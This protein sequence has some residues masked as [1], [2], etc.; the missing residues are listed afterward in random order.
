MEMYL[1]YHEE[2]E[3]LVKNFPEIQRIRFWMTFSKE[4]LNHLHVLQNVGL[5]S[6][7][8]I[9]FENH[10]VIPLKFLKTILPEPSTLGPV[11]KGKT[12]IGCLTEGIKMGKD[13]K[14]YI[15]TNCDHEASFREIGS[16]AISYT[17][18][19]PAMVGAKLILQQ[20]WQGNGV[21]NVEEFDPLPFLEDLSQFGL[22]WEEKFL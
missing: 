8:P 6:I 20:K 7:K 2:L 18:G 9:Q 1:M 11:T 21:F 19:V 5:T 4:Y 16:Q 17:T 10:Q 14:Y 12:C 3:S 13:K 22:P 15:Y